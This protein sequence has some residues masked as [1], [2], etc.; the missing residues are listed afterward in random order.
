MGYAHL[1]VLIVLFLPAC[2]LYPMYDL[3]APDIGAHFQG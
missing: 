1:M 3:P 2:M